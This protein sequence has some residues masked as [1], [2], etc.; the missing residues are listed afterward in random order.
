MMGI[1]LTSVEQSPKRS[2]RKRSQNLN[3]SLTTCW[4][5]LKMDLD[6]FPY[7]IQVSQLLT[8]NDKIRRKAMC[9][10]LLRKIE[11][12]HSFLSHLWTSDEAH[13]HLHGAVNSK[14]NIFWGRDSDSLGF[15]LPQK[16]LFL[17][18]TAP[19]K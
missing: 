14:N 11:T 10:A 2:L 9:A 4:R 19:C 18:L 16:M 6:V 1:N 8:E 5:L 7:R 13:F 3:V 15:S 17:L 12:N